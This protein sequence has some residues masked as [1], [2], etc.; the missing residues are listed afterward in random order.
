MSKR[1]AHLLV[2]D[3]LDA[4]RK[5]DLF[6]GDM[7]KQAFLLDEKTRDAVIRNIEVIGEAANQLPNDFYTTYPEIPWRNIIGL[8]N[9]VIHEYFAI[10]DTIL[11]NTITQSLPVF[12]IALQALLA[13]INTG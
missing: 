2:E 7:N 13:K 4:I 10:N 5:I 6:V 9:R 1:I 11:W 12:K 3:M 8:R